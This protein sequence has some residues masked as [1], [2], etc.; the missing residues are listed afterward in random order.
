Q[1]APRVAY[2][3][4]GPSAARVTATWRPCTSITAAT[5]RARTRSMPGS[6]WDRAGAAGGADGRWGERSVTLMRGSSSGDGEEAMNG[7]HRAASRGGAVP[8]SLR[9]ARR[10]VLPGDQGAG[11]TRPL[12]Y[13]KITSCTRSRSPSFAHRPE[14][15]RRSALRRQRSPQEHERLALPAAAAQAH[16]G[17]AAAAP[18]QLVHHVHHEPRPGG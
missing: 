9:G 7:V 8:A 6:R 16:R 2:S 18:G 15:P 5:H 13:A 14:G 1:A 10:V 3:S 11:E 17:G 12:S 4:T